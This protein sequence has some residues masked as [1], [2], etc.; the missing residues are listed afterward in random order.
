MST[1]EDTDEG[2]DQS[3]NKTKP[4]LPW[5]EIIGLLECGCKIGTD[6]NKKT[7]YAGHD[8]SCLKHWWKGKQDDGANEK[9][10]E[11]FLGVCAGEQAE[12][13]DKATSFGNYITSCSFL[14]VDAV[15]V[16]GGTFGI[17]LY[18]CRIDMRSV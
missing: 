18:G 8:Q 7:N 4:Y 13:R 1:G 15:A 11:R 9:L 10:P 17:Y 6:S 3:S 14:T 12:A 2:T 5:L 16:L